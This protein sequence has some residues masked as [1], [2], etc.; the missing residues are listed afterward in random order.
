M[1]LL[2]AFLQYLLIKK[3]IVD[4]NLN[5]KKGLGILYFIVLLSSFNYVVIIR[6]FLQV[7][8]VQ[9][10]ESSGE[11]LFT[12][13]FSTIIIHKTDI[14]GYYTI[15][16]KG[17]RQKPWFGLLVKTVNDQSF[18]LTEQN[19]KSIEPLKEYLEQENLTNLGEKKP[20]FFL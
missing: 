2:T 12:K 17:S 3:G 20:F 11:I 7:L 1:L 6:S 18:R 14:A 19:L 16:Y 8:K 4:G 15:I 13:L 9:I 10:D 5:D